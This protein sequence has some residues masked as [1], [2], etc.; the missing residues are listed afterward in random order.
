MQVAKERQE[1]AV[2]AAKRARG[3]LAAARARF[4]RWQE[5]QVEK[6]DPRSVDIELSGLHKRMA[7]LLLHISEPDIDEA[8]MLN[9]IKTDQA[10]VL[11]Q[12]V[13]SN[14]TLEIIR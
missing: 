10:S 1:L 12:A 9:Q 11:R 13:R 4:N 6:I 2:A 8:V 7:A 3:Q 14:R 5:T